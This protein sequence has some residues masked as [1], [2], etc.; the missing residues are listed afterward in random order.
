MPCVRA[1]PTHPTRSWLGLV[2]WLAATLAA[3]A[4]GGIA[5][6]SAPDFYAQLSKPAWAPPAS[7]FGPVWT[8][9]YILMGIAAWLVWR[10]RG[11]SGARGALTLFI[12]QLALNALWSWLF[13]AWRRGG[14]AFAEV[15]VLA[16]MI[17]AT[18]VAFARVRTVSA[19]LMAPYL[20]W[21]LF[22][23]ALTWSVWQQNPQLLGS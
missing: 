18:V 21:V 2:G 10:E 11:W 13:F 22:A 20:A 5:S 16:V 14:M 12:I 23:S 9:L 3:G 17:V 15:V 19:A 6:R 8:T 4:V 7:L 1:M